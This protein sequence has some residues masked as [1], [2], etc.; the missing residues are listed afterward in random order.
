MQGERLPPEVVSRA[1]RRRFFYSIPG[2]GRPL[3]LGRTASYDAARQGVFPIEQYG[4][5]KLIRRTVWDAELKRLKLRRSRPKRRPRQ[6]RA[7]AEET[8]TI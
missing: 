2:A 5:L 6:A 4:R 7:A 8:T 3:G 1:L